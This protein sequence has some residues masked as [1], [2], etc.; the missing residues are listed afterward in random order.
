MR[1]PHAF[2]A[3][4]AAVVVVDLT[5]VPGYYYYCQRA[6]DRVHRKQRS[7]QWVQWLQYMLTIQVRTVQASTGVLTCVMTLLCYAVLCF[8]GPNMCSKHD[9]E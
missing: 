9:V 8:R 1:K 7:Q 2:A 6:S 3:A 4:A 5:A